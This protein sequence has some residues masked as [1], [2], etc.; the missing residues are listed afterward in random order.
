MPINSILVRPIYWQKN[1]LIDRLGPTFRQADEL[2]QKDLFFQ[3]LYRVW[4]DLFPIN[5]D[6][7]YADN[8]EAH[9]KVMRHEQIVGLNPL[10][11][12]ATYF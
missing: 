6:W 7:S 10:G 4:F 5:I 11:Q 2:G 1:D 9:E 3:L 8:P 12:F